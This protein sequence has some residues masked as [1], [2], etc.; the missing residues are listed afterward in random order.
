MQ[1]NWIP[2][3]LSLDETIESVF[4]DRPVEVNALREHYPNIKHIKVQFYDVKKHPENFN[5]Y[6]YLNELCQL[7]SFES[8]ICNPMEMPAL[9]AALWRNPLKYLDLNL[10]KIKDTNPFAE[11]PSDFNN[12]LET[13]YLRNTQFIPEALFDSKTIKTILLC[14]IE[15]AITGIQLATQLENLT[16]EG[17][18]YAAHGI[19]LHN[20]NNLKQ[21]V[22]NYCFF[23]TLPD[24]SALRNLKRLELHNLNHLKSL[25]NNWDALNKLELLI[26]KNIHNDKD[27]TLYFNELPCLKQL[28]IHSVRASDDKPFL[29]A[30][31]VL[32]SIDFSM[33]ALTSYPDALFAS[34][35][36]NTYIIR[37]ASEWT[38]IPNKWLNHHPNGLSIEI[39]GCYNLIIPNNI[40]TKSDLTTF[41]HDYPRYSKIKI[42]NTVLKTK[43]LEY[44]VGVPNEQRLTLGYLLFGGR[45]DLSEWA[46]FKAHFFKL[47]NIK[48]SII[49]SLVREN[50]HLLNP[51]NHQPIIPTTDFVGKTITI[52]GNTYKPK[53]VYKEKLIA[54]NINYQS[55]VKKD[56]DWLIVGDAVETPSNFWN[57]PH[58]FFTE[59]A[60]DVFLK[61]TNPGFLQTADRLECDNLRA[62]LW[63]NDPANERL[64]VEMIKTAGIPAEILPD[65]VLVAKNST[66]ETVK[67]T[68]RKLL[69]VEISAEV[70]KIVSGQHRLSKPQLFI[71]YGHLAP[72]FDVSQMVVC[73]YKRTG[74]FLKTFFQLPQS[75]NNP[76]R[77]ELFEIARQSLKP[78]GKNWDT[79]YWC[80][81]EAELKMIK[82]SPPNR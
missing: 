4:L 28:T 60:L 77:K 56:T 65:L 20:L 3:N 38:T 45:E 10:H 21:L 42:E 29:G 43:L 2:Q 32:E 66:D 75:L 27:K 82:S 81:T 47:L 79:S 73:E 24:W 25:E 70:Q 13:L 78:K 69:K 17:I 31:P 6:D 14:N 37:Y 9:P 53:R 26:L 64:V 34:P 58:Q 57:Y 22:F 50:L 35:H 51:P 52:L 72:D 19:Q 59:Q 11:L 44:L 7:F 67:T 12:H 48:N 80:F 71:R 5:M 74:Q 46:N 49:K 23:E 62:L 30:M 1:Y 76:Y 63:S 61:E 33:L 39:M 41:I 55:I 54:L 36:L 8:F 18:S 68:L 15:C 40:L 16:F